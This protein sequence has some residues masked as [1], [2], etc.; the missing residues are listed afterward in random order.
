M[1]SYWN[2]RS[3][4]ITVVAA[5]PLTAR[6]L[7]WVT[8]AATV[9][10]SATVIV[11]DCPAAWILRPRW[12]C[13]EVGLGVEHFLQ[14]QVREDFAQFKVVLVVPPWQED[15][16]GSRGGG[17]KGQGGVG[18]CLQSG[19]G[20]PGIRQHEPHHEPLGIEQVHGLSA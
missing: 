11:A 9:P 10:F 12:I 6:A 15:L 1:I 19:H 14:A 4:W 16:H 18:G 17:F 8:A 13:V 5:T 2:G 3:K 20:G 7:I